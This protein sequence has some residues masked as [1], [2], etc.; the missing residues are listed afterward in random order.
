MTFKSHKLP[1]KIKYT[2]N[3]LNGYTK[4]NRV[5]IF[6]IV[7]RQFNQYLVY[8]VPTEADFFDYIIA[9]K[10][11]IPIKDKLEHKQSYTFHTHMFVQIIAE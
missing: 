10:T 2:A 1:E 6:H 7:P 5:G 3:D 4:G 8:G 11:V 9:D